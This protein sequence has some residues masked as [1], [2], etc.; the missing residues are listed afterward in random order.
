MPRVVHDLSQIATILGLDVATVTR[1]VA[2][3]LHKKIVIKTPVDTGRARAS[4]TLNPGEPD[5]TIAPEGTELTPEAATQQ[6][7]QQ[8]AKVAN[9]KPY[10]AIFVSNSVEYIVPLEEGHSPQSP[11]HAMVAGSLAEVEAELKTIVE[12]AR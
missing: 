2:L 7:L 8:Q 3:D 1:R 9:T 6:A 5:R 4:W 12:S 10:E 11:P